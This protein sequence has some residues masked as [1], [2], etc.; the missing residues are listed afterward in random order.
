MGKAKNE[1]IDDTYINAF[2]V[3]KRCP[4]LYR[5]PTCGNYTNSIMT[6]PVLCFPCQEKRDFVGYGWEEDY[7]YDYWKM[8]EIEKIHIG[9]SN[10][11]SGGILNARQTQCVSGQG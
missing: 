4:P 3:I 10:I 8:K 2:G 6:P 7:N 1:M 5:C 9:F 11:K